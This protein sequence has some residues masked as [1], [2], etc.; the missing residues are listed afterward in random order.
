VVLAVPVAPP[1]AAPDFEGIADE[2]VCVETP[3]GFF[4]VGQWYR[5]FSQTSDA[6]VIASLRAAAAPGVGGEV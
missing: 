5:D 1:T 6:E 4:A 2:L 3:G